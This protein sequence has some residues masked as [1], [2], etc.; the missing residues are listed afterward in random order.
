MNGFIYHIKDPNSPDL[1]HGYIGV[2]KESKGV[3]KR[4]REH[5][6]DKNRIMSHNIRE[7]NIKLDD[8]EILFFG[9]IMECYKKEEELRPTQNMGWNLA[10]GGGG[11]YYS[12]IEDLNRY[13][14]EIQTQRMQ[15]EDLKKQQGESFKKN[16]Y[17]NQDSQMLRSK[18]AK[19]HMANPEKKKRALAGLHSKHKCPYCE[20][21][22]NKGNLTK[23]IK[24][25][26]ND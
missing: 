3:A 21:E 5:C 16:Y 22:S 8:I 15:N 26:H 13:R 4:F 14:S 7:N 24:A 25:K 12:E 6:L 9:D 2:V 11:P 17:S 1:N 10:K 23:H 19:E 18:R 20:F